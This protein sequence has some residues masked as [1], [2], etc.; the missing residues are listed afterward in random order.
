[1]EGASTDESIRVLALSGE[2]EHFCSGFDLIRRN[3]ENAPRPRV[4]SIQRR[5]HLHAHR[6]IPAMLS[7][8]IPIVCAARGYVAGIGLHLLLA[9]DF[10]VVARSARLWEPFVKR[11]FSPDSGGSWLLPRLVGIARAKAMLMLG[12]EVSGEEAMGWGLVHAAVEESEVAAR[13]EALVEEFG[14]SAT[15]AVGLAK[16]LVERGLAASFENSLANEAFAMELSSRSQDFK[17][18]MKA[19]REKRPPEYRGD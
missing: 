3:R 11:G 7:V 8:Q 1:M 16:W 17:E 19:L 15:V 6:L 13:A 4:G 10:A 9:S 2:G 12:R 14:R 18:G 5:L